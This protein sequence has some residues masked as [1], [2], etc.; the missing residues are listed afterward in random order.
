TAATEH[1]AVLDSC[2]AAEHSS[3]L[4]AI[5]L[6]P[7]PDGLLDPAKIKGAIDERTLLV[8]VMFANNE[9][10]VL[11]DIPAIG[12]LCKERGAIFHSDAAQAAGKVPIDVR[13]MDIHLLSISAHKLYG[14]KGIGALYVRKRSP[15]V[16]LTPLIDGGGHEHGLRS[17]TLNVPGIVG[18][19]AACELA[20]TE[21]K[22]EAERLKKLRDRLWNGL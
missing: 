8:S 17:G 16:K 4:Y 5:H 22:S 1:P 3:K 14:P 10:G 11:Q 18:F 12:A 7:G 6:R 15:R 20:R 9:I 19:G 21:M 13:A 2:A